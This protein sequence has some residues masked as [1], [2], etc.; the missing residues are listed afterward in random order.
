MRSRCYVTLSLD[1]LQLRNKT[2]LTEQE[3]CLLNSRSLFC[4]LL[5]VYLLVFQLNPEACVWMLRIC[6]RSDDE[7]ESE[8]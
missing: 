6:F 5:R 7:S 2:H 4:P 3:T 1:L 8:N